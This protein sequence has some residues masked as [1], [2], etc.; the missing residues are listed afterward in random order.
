MPPVCDT[1]AY[2][3]S[4]FAGMGVTHPP[5]TTAASTEASTNPAGLGYPGPASMGF[6]GMPPPSLASSYPALFPKFHGHPGAMGGYRLP[7]PPVPMPEDDDVKDDP[8]VTLEH[9]D[10]WEAFNNHGTEMVIT[11]SGR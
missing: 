6:P 11:K 5:T 4:M 1:M 2:S 10:M 9:K 3:P 8:K 7:P